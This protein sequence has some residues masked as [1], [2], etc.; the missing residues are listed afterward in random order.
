M[1]KC[2]HEGNLIYSAYFK[3]FIRG[4]EIDQEGFIYILCS[5]SDSQ[6]FKLDTNM[7]AV[8]ETGV[9]ASEYLG[10]AYQLLVIS[11]LVLVCSKDKKKDLYF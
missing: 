3:K 10:I 9:K 2:D 6:V 4:I 11:E 7:N 5:A 1:R 8:R